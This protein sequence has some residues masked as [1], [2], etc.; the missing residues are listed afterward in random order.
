MA[1]KSRDSRAKAGRLSFAAI[2]LGIAIVVALAF[3]RLDNFPYT[4]SCTAAWRGIGRNNQKKN[5]SPSWIP[6]EPCAS[7][8]RQTSGMS[9]MKCAIYAPPT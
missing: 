1:A 6:I 9:W 2:V 5:G 8:R 4:L 7:S 3:R